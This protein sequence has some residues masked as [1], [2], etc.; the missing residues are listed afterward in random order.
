MRRKNR[1][2]ITADRERIKTEVK[3]KKMQL[4]VLKN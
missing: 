1:N 4:R 2:K 3:L